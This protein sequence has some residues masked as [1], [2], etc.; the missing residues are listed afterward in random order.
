MT[1]KI[2]V[3]VKVED[4]VEVL[5]LLQGQAK[6]MRKRLDGTKAY[7]SLRCETLLDKWATQARACQ[8]EH[9]DTL[10]NKNVE[11]DVLVVPS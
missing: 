7:T 3:I 11:E 6:A 1:Y 4:D 9:A 2:E 8:E 10:A 5:Q